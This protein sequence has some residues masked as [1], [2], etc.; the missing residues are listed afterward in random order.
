MR[1]AILP[2][3][4]V[5]ILCLLAL[6]ITHLGKF[7]IYGSSGVNEFHVVPVNEFFLEQ[8]ATERSGEIMSSFVTVAIDFVGLEYGDVVWGDYDN[9]HDLDVLISGLD[10]SNQSRTILYRNDGNTFTE[11]NT[12]LP[13]VNQSSLDFGDYDRDGDLDLLIMGN[14]D[15]D[16]Y[17]DPGDVFISRV[18]RNTN[19]VFTDIEAGLP[20]MTW[21]GAEW[22]DFE[23]DGD[24]D[25][26][27]SGH[28]GVLDVEARVYVNNNGMFNDFVQVCTPSEFSNECY[29]AQGS[30]TWADYDED[31]DLDILM[32][33]L[34]TEFFKADKTTLYRNNGGMYEQVIHEM[35]GVFHGH[36][37]WADFDNDGDL[38]V[39]VSGTTDYDIVDR[40]A[41]V[42]RNNNKVFSRYLGLTGVSQ[43][44]TAWADYT[45]NGSADLATT[46][47]GLTRVYTNN[48]G[49]LQEFT[50]T[51]DPRHNSAMG[52]ADY[53]NDGDLDFLVIGADEAGVPQTTLYENTTTLKNAPPSAPS[54][55]IAYSEEDVTRVQLVFVY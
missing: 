23:G 15:S 3:L 31:N 55:L 9:D 16:G 13:G 38:D 33:G 37:S 10:A 17:P 1:I 49:G 40:E 32:T 35:A 6:S 8:D 44:E 47:S 14:T 46:G 54:N 53:D 43:G 18:Y 2:L 5:I 30:A 7:E 25:I 21:G 45:N 36:A 12:D 26:L 27:L 48:N 28:T 20:G 19:G 11:I 41:V 29:I 22:G 51:F 34:D 42:Y 50:H 24:L 4:S 39:V 52:W